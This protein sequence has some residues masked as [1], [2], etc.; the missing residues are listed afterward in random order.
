MTAI[1]T[2]TANPA[3]DIWGQCDAV[4]PTEKNRIR[5]VRYDAGGGGIN[6]ARVLE[7][8]GVQAFPVYLAGGA[9]GPLF[10]TLLQR[11][12]PRGLKVEIDGD[13]RLSEVVYDLATGHEFRFVA[14]GPVI[15]EQECRRALE[16][17][18]GVL[19]SHT[20][21]G[22]F[23]ASG[24]LPRGLPEH[25]YRDLADRVHAKGLRFALDCSGAALRRSCAEGTIDLLK[26]SRSEL[27]EL[28]DHPLVNRQD[29]ETAARDLVAGGRVA[30]VLVSLGPDGALLVDREHVVH[31]AA[32]PVTVKSTVGA[33]DSFL[34]GFLYGLTQ[35]ASPQQALQ[36]AILAGSAACLNPGTQLVNKAQFEALGQGSGR[37]SEPRL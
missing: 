20:A 16:T 15:S 30:Q 24:S 19:D 6:V 21:G 3:I 28:A 8:L 9:T 10:E 4:V 34:G 29:I 36:T 14:E 37:P 26:L 27:G 13:T 31:A 17:V 2:Y 18:S 5:D 22:W 7:A 23:V 11:V 1:I 32:L 12:L 35:G 33:G 25:H